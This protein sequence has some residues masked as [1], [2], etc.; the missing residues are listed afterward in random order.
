MYIQSRLNQNLSCLSLLLL[1]E[2]LRQFRHLLK[3]IP[4]QANISHLEDGSVPVFI[5]AGNHFAVF[6]ARQ[7]LDRPR[8]ARAEVQLRGNVLAGLSNLQAVV[9]ETTVDCCPRRANRGSKSVSQ[10]RNELVKLLFRLE[11]SSARYHLAGRCEVWS[12]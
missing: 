1:L 5:D 2:F 12:V 9:R 6:H 11:A 10:R 7:M 8:D 3:Q 4:N